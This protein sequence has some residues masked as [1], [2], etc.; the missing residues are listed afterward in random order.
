MQAIEQS[1]LELLAP[2]PQGEEERLEM[3]E[4]KKLRNTDIEEKS[5]FTIVHKVKN[6]SSMLGG[7]RQSI[8]HKLAQAPEVLRSN[9]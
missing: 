2:R 8:S 6:L 7:I 5:K 4:R 3:D 9:M 1:Q